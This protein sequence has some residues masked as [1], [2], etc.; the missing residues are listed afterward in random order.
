MGFPAVFIE[1]QDANRGCCGRKDVAMRN[2]VANFHI[3]DGF[4]YD[5]A[6]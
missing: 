4:S 2:G 1:T 3:Q 5:G 6:C